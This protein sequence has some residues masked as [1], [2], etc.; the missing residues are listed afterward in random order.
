MA[1]EI[2]NQYYG[3]NTKLLI[4]DWWKAFEEKITD[5]DLLFSGEKEWDLPAWMHENLNPINAELMWEFGPGLKGGHRLV[6]T[7]ENSFFLRPLAN[8]I[9]SQA[10]TINNW[11][12]YTYRLP[13]QDLDDVRSAIEGRSNAK[14]LALGISFKRDN[15]NTVGIFVHFD[16]QSLIDKDL[17]DQQAFILTETLLGEKY[18]DKWVGFIE[19]IE[20]TEP[21]VP[22]E[23]VYVEFEEFVNGIRA[24][25]PKQPLYADI[26][27]SDW[28]ILL[29]DPEEQTDYCERDDMFVAKTRYQPLMKAISEMPMFFPERY[30][31]NNEIFCYLKMDGSEG[32][33]EEKF[34]DKKEIENALD[35]VLIE[36][37][38]GCA[39]G[40]GTGLRYSYIDFALTDF[41]KAITEILA[42]LRKGNL[43]KRSWILF[44]DPYAKAQWIGVW[45][46]SPTPLLNIE[47]D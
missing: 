15:F 6:I 25:L 37:K 33:D 24:E 7:P 34:A 30:S 32:L 45:E 41:K 4:D 31:R 47:M 13:T 12:F 27:E 38:L 3:N 9:V 18:L 29:S 28:A 21:Y 5:L 8:Q 17:V 35:A 44:F 11:E 46:N 19:P 14:N 10:P 16:K 2:K 39:I 36:N 26:P 43:T 1:W 20:P 23:Q 22:L 42:V 40:G